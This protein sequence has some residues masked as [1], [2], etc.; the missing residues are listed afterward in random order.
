M[1]SPTNSSGASGA[2]LL[3]EK[4]ARLVGGGSGSAR[5]VDAEAMRSL[6]AERARVLATPRAQ[7]DP[8][9]AADKTDVLVFIVGTE[10]L[11]LPLESIVGVM[12]GAIIAP[13]PRAVAPVFGV[14]AWRGRPLTVLSLGARAASSGTESRL[15]VL[16]SGRR[17]AVGLLTDSIDDTRVVSRS[18][19]TPALAGPRRHLAI[20]VTDD[21]V[22]V[23]DAD[24]L[25]NAV[26]TA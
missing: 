8:A 15:I 3:D 5:K 11:A 16:G 18:A 23:L 2:G 7:H 1:T 19:L 20:G 12:R 25:L 6:L 21:A 4:L 24:L 14:S 26:A 22:L 17:A 9:A 13:L 10:R